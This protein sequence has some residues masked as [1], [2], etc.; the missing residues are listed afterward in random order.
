MSSILVYQ[1][2]VVFSDLSA[3]R[4]ARLAEVERRWEEKKQSL[5]EEL[6]RVEKLLAGAYD[7]SAGILSLP[8]SLP[9]PSSL[10]PP[11]PSPT[12]VHTCNTIHHSHAYTLSGC[13]RYLT[14]H[15]PPPS[16]IPLNITLS[17]PQKNFIATDVLLKPE[18]NM[19]IILKKLRS[20]ME[21]EGLEIVE[22]PPCNEFEI[23]IIR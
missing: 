23:S 17:V 13:H 21:K 3:D 10:S 7:R 2:T 18:E 1:V 8:P 15:L 6:A 14:E 12:Y 11:P 4:Q 5:T 19:A 22:F 20:L 16:T 9:P